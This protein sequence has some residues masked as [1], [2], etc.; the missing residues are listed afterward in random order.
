MI[1]TVLILTALLL[2]PGWAEEPVSTEQPLAAAEMHITQI[3]RQIVKGSQ[4]R[5]P[6]D[7]QEAFVTRIAREMA[8]EI[9]LDPTQ[10]AAEQQRQEE[11]KRERENLRNSILINIGKGLLIIIILLILRWLIGLIGR[12]V[13]T[14]EAKARNLSLKKMGADPEG[15][16][17]LISTNSES[18]AAELG[19]RLIS[20]RLSA[21]VDIANP[22][23]FLVLDQGKIQKKTGALML[24]KTRRR[25]LKKLV[26]RVCEQ[27]SDADILPFPLIQG[28][29]PAMKRLKQHTRRRFG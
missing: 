6:N 2:T 1:L 19:R 5:L 12:A 11:R 15:L 29:K 4:K 10:V 25:R 9:A 14:E 16:A 7:T 3:A 22:L 27:H 28:S 17:V 23:Q 26:R 20:E 18:E 24:V 21:G 8:R 13:A